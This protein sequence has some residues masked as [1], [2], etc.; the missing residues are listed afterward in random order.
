MG[1][2][3]KLI[4]IRIKELRDSLNISQTDLAKNAKTSLTTI[5]RLE[6]GHQ[7]PQSET[8]DNIIAAL[9]AEMEEIV[10]I[11]KKASNNKAELLTTLYSR[12]PSL[13]EE[14]LETLIL[15]LDGIR[16][17]ETTSAV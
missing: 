14:E 2:I 16:P 5:S 4:G 10:P 9:G 11:E 8:L 7:L 13:D 15:L 3:E 12:L 6:N 17:L 1:K